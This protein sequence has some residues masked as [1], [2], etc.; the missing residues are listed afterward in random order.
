MCLAGETESL[1]RAGI[2]SPIVL[3]AVAGLVS[4]TLGLIRT[5]P[6]AAGSTGPRRTQVDPVA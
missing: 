1:I 6:T 3:R 4:H 5:E 2:P